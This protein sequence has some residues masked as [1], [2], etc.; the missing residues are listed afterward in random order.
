MK[1]Q[2]LNFFINYGHVIVFALLEMILIPLIKKT[3]IKKVT[4]KIDE[5][6]PSAQLKEVNKELKEI[7]R[8]IMEMRGKVK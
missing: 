2:I 7:K 6:E 4:K 3:I 8:E 5:V 1:E